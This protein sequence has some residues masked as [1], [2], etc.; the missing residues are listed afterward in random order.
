MG[1]WRVYINKYF[2]TSENKLVLP[3]SPFGGDVGDIHVVNAAPSD[4]GQVARDVRLVESSVKNVIEVF[5]DTL[6]LRSSYRTRVLVSLMCST[7][8]T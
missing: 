5:G 3:Y 6:L 4:M 8:F 2:Q 1:P 7:N